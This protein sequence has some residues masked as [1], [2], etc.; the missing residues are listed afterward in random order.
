MAILYKE[1]RMAEQIHKKIK[2]FIEKNQLIE[3]G[4]EL[5][6]GVSGGMDSMMLL[7][8]FYTY[9]EVYQVSLKV[10]HIHHGI[11]ESADLDAAL[12]EE[13]CRAYHI[14]FYRHNCNIKALA[15]QK[16][17]QRK[18]L[19]EKKDTISLYLY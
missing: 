10:A 15:K 9:K 6:L 5:I 19:E 16:N 18:R 4:N 2:R 8:Y 14:P 12:V 3:Q 1:R 13:T 11:R 17:A 7:H